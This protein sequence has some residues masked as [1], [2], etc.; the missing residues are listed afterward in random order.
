MCIYI[1]I[2]MNAFITTYA[3]QIANMIWMDV[4]CSMCRIYPV[5]CVGFSLCLR[6]RF[7]LLAIGIPGCAAASDCLRQTGTLV[8]P[9][10]DLS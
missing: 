2:R 10:R 9:N 6:L 5:L 7:G 8:P 1:R 4:V 3:Y